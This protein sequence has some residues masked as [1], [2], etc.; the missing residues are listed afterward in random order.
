MLLECAVG[1]AFGAGYVDNEEAL[2]RWCGEVEKGHAEHGKHPGIRTGMYTADTQMTI[3]IAEAIVSGDGW[4]SGNIVKHFLACFLRDPRDGYA[5]RFRAFLE[6]EA[7]Q[8]PEGF[9]AN[10]QP[11][12][13]D[14]GAAV[15]AGPIGVVCESIDKVKELATVQAEIT[16][17]TKGGV[18][19]ACAAALMGWF[20]HNTSEPKRYLPG[21]LGAHVPGYRWKTPW[22]GKAGVEGMPCTHA[23]LTAIVEC[24]GQTEMLGWIV[25]LRGQVG[26]VAAIALSAASSPYLG[27]PVKENVASN[28]IDTLENG[29]FGRDYLIG[30][31][32]RLRKATVKSS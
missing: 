1:D 29:G 17:R 7:N 27:M 4:T 11:E 26:T 25:R 20:L 21:F 30:L 19:S 18:D 13:E 9:L 15:R 12:S 5:R 22:R 32:K 3:A 28:L 23:A 24:P 14:P 2:Q 31:D 16:H 6:D 10:I 8:T